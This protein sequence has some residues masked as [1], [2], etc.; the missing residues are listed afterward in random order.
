M[1]ALYANASSDTPICFGRV[2]LMD[3]S[4]N[5]FLG[6]IKSL[7]ART[8]ADRSI[9]AVP[10]LAGG[11]ANHFWTSQ[12]FLRLDEKCGV[13]TLAKLYSRM[14][15]DEDD[16]SKCEGAKH[17]YRFID[18]ATVELH[19]DHIHCTP[20][21]EVVTAETKTFDLNKLLEDSSVRVMEP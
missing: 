17:T 5:Y 16:G 14:H 6:K 11:E 7:E 20:T 19:R 2:E 15:Y 4:G 9:V 12:A 1:L 10:S 13:T 8:L 3:T 18:A 21:D